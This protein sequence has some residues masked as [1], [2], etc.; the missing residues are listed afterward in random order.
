MSE[1]RKTQKG[2]GVKSGRGKNGMKG[3]GR[4]GKRDII[5]PILEPGWLFSMSL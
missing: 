4:Q 2:K 3:R 1:R 5:Y